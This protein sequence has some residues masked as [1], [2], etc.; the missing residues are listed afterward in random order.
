MAER[1]KAAEDRE[2]IFP[3]GAEGRSRKEDCFSKAENMAL[4]LA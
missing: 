4:G 1:A 3:K 2:N